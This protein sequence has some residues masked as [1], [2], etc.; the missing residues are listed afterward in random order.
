M[1]TRA[2]VGQSVMRGACVS[3]S[4]SCIGHASTRHSSAHV[5]AARLKCTTNGN[6][7]HRVGFG[8]NCEFNVIALCLCALCVRTVLP[9]ARNRCRN[10]LATRC[11]NALR[12]MKMCMCSADVWHLKGDIQPIFAE[13]MR[14]R[15]II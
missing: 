11:L 4:A 15:D 5:H 8:D 1:E 12:Y 14:A 7:G 2:A 9:C 3:G 10:Q 6:C 13:N